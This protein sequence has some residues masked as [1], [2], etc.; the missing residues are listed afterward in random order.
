VS[1]VVSDMASYEVSDVVSDVV[2]DMASYEVSDVA[3]D[4][5]SDVVS[6]VALVFPYILLHRHEVRTVR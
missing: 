4:V 6:D 5:V 1:D 3:S 2:S